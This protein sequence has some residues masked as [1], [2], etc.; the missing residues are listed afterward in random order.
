MSEPGVS[1]LH[2]MSVP[3]KTT[4][5]Y[6]GPTDGET[7]QIIFCLPSSIGI[8]TP[9]AILNLLAGEKR[10]S[11]NT[12]QELRSLLNH[13][14]LLLPFPAVVLV[15]TED[16]DPLATVETNLLN[17]CTV[18]SKASDRVY[19]RDKEPNLANIRPGRR[20]ALLIAEGIR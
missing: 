9:A 12:A 13:Q 20:I 7:K 2:N 15:K 19:L 1:L 10:D 8:C 14:A 18:L 5:V 6:T 17:I 3:S 11:T 16:V 4:I